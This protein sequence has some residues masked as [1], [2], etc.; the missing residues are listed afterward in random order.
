MRRR[1]AGITLLEFMVAASILSVLAGL[2]LD[3]LHYYQEVAEKTHMQATL[4]AMQSGLRFEM[5]RELMAGREIDYQRLARENP[6]NWLEKKPANYLGEYRHDGEG[7]KRGAWY[8]D[9]VNHELIYL[10]AL[11]GHF[12][13]SVEGQARVRYRVELMAGKDGSAIMTARLREVEAYSW[14]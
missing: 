12:V 2:L 4:R 3:R 8:F 7:L 6:I 11:N 14:F 10:P 9:T 1:Q 5:A 13:P